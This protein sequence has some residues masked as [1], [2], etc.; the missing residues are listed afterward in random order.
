MAKKVVGKEIRFLNAL[1]SGKVIS[2][3]QAKANYRLGNPSATVLRIEESGYM[4]TRTYSTKITRI[5]QS[6]IPVRTVKYNIEI[7]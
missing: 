7:I 2:R 6:R 1:L 5:N 3:R 4:L